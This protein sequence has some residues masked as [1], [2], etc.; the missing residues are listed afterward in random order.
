MVAES[1]NIRLQQSMAFRR[2]VNFLPV[3]W[4][5]PCSFLTS[6][7]IWDTKGKSSRQIVDQQCAR[8]VGASAFWT[9]KINDEVRKLLM[10]AFRSKAEMRET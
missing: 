10:L 2:P 6:K 3:A 4:L 9:S 5:A 8:I 7:H 1:R